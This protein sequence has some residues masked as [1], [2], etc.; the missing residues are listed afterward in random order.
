MRRLIALLMFCL[1]IGSCTSCSRGVRDTYV[2]FSAWNQ[3]ESSVRIAVVCNGF[4]I[5]AGSGFVVAERKIITAGHLKACESPVYVIKYRENNIIKETFAVVDK[6]LDDVDVMSLKTW[7]D[8]PVKANVKNKKVLV[9]DKVCSIGGGTITYGWIK[10]CGYVSQF[11]NNDIIISINTV[12]G[13]SGSPLYN[14]DGFVVAVI[15]AG[16]WFDYEEKIGF[17]IPV[18]VW[19]ELL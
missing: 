6:T 18:S 14:S 8:I 2:D 9:G 10:K 19:K 7:D 1:I 4:P 16:Q 15:V 5:G 17:A 13:N 3:Y 12:P 11:T